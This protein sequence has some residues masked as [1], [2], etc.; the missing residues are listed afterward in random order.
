MSSD[1]SGASEEAKQ[2]REPQLQPIVGSLWTLV[3]VYGPPWMAP[4]AGFEVKRRSL[5]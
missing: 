2:L 4:R 1:V 5:N 3:D